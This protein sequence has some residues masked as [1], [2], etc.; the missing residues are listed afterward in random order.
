MPVHC[1]GQGRQHALFGLAPVRDYAPV[2]HG[3]GHQVVAD[4]Q[5]VNQ[6][7]LVLSPLAVPHLPWACAAVFVLRHGPMHLL[8]YTLKLLGL[9]EAIHRWLGALGTLETDRREKVARYAE[10]IAATLGRAAAAFAVLDKDPAS[11]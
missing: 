10:A 11:A 4:R 5:T 2:L 8:D 9:S 1:S 3:P 6:F 7:S